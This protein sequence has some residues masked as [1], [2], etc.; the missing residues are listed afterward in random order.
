MKKVKDPLEVGVYMDYDN[1]KLEL[2][3][4]VQENNTTTE[5]RKEFS[6]FEEAYKYGQQFN[7]GKNKRQILATDFGY[8]TVG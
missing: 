8:K 2:R 5:F 4:V 7:V 6:T 3:I 1:P